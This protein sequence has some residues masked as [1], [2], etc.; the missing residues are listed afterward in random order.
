MRLRRAT[1]NT[2]KTFDQFD[3]DRMRE[4]QPRADTGPRR[5][6]HT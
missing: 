2:S 3:F 4:A 1:C 5:R 6:P